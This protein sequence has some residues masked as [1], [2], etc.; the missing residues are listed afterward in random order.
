MEDELM[1][2][3]AGHVLVACEDIEHIADVQMYPRLKIAAQMA[4]ALV[5]HALQHTPWDIARRAVVLADAL[6][7]V[8]DEPA[9]PE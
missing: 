3:V 2:I 7:E 4:A 8:C 6:I 5:P 9:K 1:D